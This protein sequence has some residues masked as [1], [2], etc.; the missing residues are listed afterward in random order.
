MKKQLLFIQISKSKNPQITTNIKNDRTR[1]NI[2]TFEIL[3]KSFFLEN[4]LKS[5][6]ETPSSQTVVFTYNKRKKVIT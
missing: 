4:N 1:Y 5:H 6:A 2:N 3:E